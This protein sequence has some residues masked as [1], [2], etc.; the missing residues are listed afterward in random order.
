MDSHGS[1]TAHGR[2]ARGQIEV[3]VPGVGR[4]RVA[5]GATVVRAQP[6]PDAGEAA[7][8][9]AYERL[10]LPFVLQQR[11]H[12]VLHAS[13]ALIGDRA[14][15]FCGP[16]RSGKSS[17]AAA[18]DAAGRR[19]LADD[20]LVWRVGDDGEV[21]VV[22][23]PF[24]LRPRIED[25]TVARD[26]RASQGRGV[27]ASVRVGCIAAL[28]WGDDDASD[29]VARQL[30]PA[31]AVLR[32]V[33][34]AYRYR[35]DDAVEKRRVFGQVLDL[36]ERVPV[37]AVELPHAPGRL[38]QVIDELEAIADAAGSPARGY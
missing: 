37:V 4:Y 13:A 24:L 3:V 15:A 19:A 30:A 11:G 36:V 32:L 9:D 33:P 34:Q 12:G 22:P 17:L 35:L 23:I 6:V 18:F 31:D 5:A 8:R 38:A 29:T 21:R 20:A 25:A 28:A 1:P 10:V 14:V 16:P 27:A 7:V 26:T 2:S